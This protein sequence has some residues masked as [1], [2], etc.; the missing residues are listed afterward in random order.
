MGNPNP[1]SKPKGKGDRIHPRALKPSFGCQGGPRAGSGP[2][3]ALPAGGGGASSRQELARC[4]GHPDKRRLWGRRRSGAAGTGSG[5]SSGQGSAT[6]PPA[7][8]RPAVPLP[9]TQNLPWPRSRGCHQRVPSPASPVPGGD[10]HRLPGRHA[11]P[12]V[13][14]LRA[15]SGHGSPPSSS[16]SGPD[17]CRTEPGKLG[18]GP[19]PVQLRPFPGCEDAAVRP[20]GSSARIRPG[21]AQLSP[22]TPRVPTGTGGKGRG[23]P[24][25]GQQQLRGPHPSV[26]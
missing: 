17:R 25:P 10:R 18:A 4:R 2:A 23:L 14:R 12:N 21:S 3:P 24:H 13:C 20:V 16:R 19:A 5:G 15:E 1:S 11:R 22:Q 9:P 8:E 6:R 26:G 7:S